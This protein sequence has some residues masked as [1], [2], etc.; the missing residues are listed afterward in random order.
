MPSNHNTTS[1]NLAAEVFG[2]LLAM[3]FGAIVGMILPGKAEGVVANAIV[4]AVVAWIFWTRR[5]DNFAQTVAVAVGVAILLWPITFVL[6]DWL[7]R[8]Y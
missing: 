5:R 8:Y 2:T 4:C 1:P 3:T 6:L 7:H